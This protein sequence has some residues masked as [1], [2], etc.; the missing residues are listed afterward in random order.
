MYTLLID[1]QDVKIRLIEEKGTNN[2]IQYN[3]LK[4]NKSILI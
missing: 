1:K 2:L 4:L 3:I